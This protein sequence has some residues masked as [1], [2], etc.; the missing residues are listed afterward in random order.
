MA[1]ASTSLPPTFPTRTYRPC[2]KRCRSRSRLLAG[3]QMRPARQPARHQGTQGAAP[4]INK[5]KGE[6]EAQLPAA[7]GAPPAQSWPKG[8]CSLVLNTNTLFL[9]S[10]LRLRA[11]R[12]HHLVQLLGTRP[13]VVAD[14]LGQCVDIRGAGSG[15]ATGIC[16]EE[17]AESMFGSE[18]TGQ[19]RTRLHLCA[20]HAMGKACQTLEAQ[21][22]RVCKLSEGC[23]A[24]HSLS[25]RPRTV[26]HAASPPLSSHGV[27]HVTCRRRLSSA[28]AAQVGR[29]QRRTGQLG[30]CCWCARVGALQQ[31]W[32]Q[33]RR[34]PEEGQEAGIAGKVLCRAPWEASQ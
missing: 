30:S 20:L 9:K 32:G 14:L 10:R 15:R 6:S 28:A 26:A 4:L 31:A 3:P 22:M 23:T 16:T 5:T 33:Q 24:P 13:S 8:R 7:L 29:T 17:Q 19:N 2:S 11:A 25:S 18:S 1:N 34:P 21:A 27:V 12:L